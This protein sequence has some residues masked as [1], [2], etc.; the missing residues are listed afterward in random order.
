[1]QEIG[2]YASLCVARFP[3]LLGKVYLRGRVCVCVG[4]P[5]GGILGALWGSCWVSRSW[6]V[7]GRSWGAL[8]L[9]WGGSGTILGG[10]GRS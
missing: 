6:P 3:F 10:L 1:M 4:V 8:G 2:T 9:S 5:F 7:L